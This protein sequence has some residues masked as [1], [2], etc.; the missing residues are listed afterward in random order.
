MSRDLVRPLRDVAYALKTDGDIAS[1]IDVGTLCWSAA[2]A[3]EEDAAP[4]QGLDQ[5]EGA[6]ERAM[7][8]SERLSQSVA[9]LLPLARGYAH[10]SY[11]HG[12]P[13]PDRLVID[14]IS[15]SDLTMPEILEAEGLMETGTPASAEGDLFEHLPTEAFLQDDVPPAPTTPG[16]TVEDA[17]LHAQRLLERL[18]ARRITGI[19]VGEAKADYEA[20]LDLLF[21][22]LQ[23][24]ASA[25]FDGPAT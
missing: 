22:R 21:V 11:E 20:A 6:A 17:L 18:N 25:S 12:G 8:R 15:G 2:D 13:S 1:G 4:Q 10:I 23:D 7:G 19:P 14:P 16:E 24:R 5:L 9:L 3:L